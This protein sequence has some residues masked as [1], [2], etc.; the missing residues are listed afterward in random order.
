MNYFVHISPLAE[1]DLREIVDYLAIAKQDVIAAG[2]VHRRLADKIKSLSI[3]TQS[4]SSSGRCDNFGQPVSCNAG[5]ELPGFLYCGSGK[6]NRG[7]RPRHIRWA[8]LEKNAL[9]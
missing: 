1:A 2:N 3:F 7:N 4:I 8:R 5:W 9:N 6:C